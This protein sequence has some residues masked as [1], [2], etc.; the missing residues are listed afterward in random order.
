LRTISLMGARLNLVCSCS[1]RMGSYG[2]AAPET[3]QP[4][5]AL[6]LAVEIQAAELS[7]HQQ[8]QDLAVDPLHSRIQGL[9]ERQHRIFGFGA[10]FKSPA[11]FGASIPSRAITLVARSGP[12]R[13][14]QRIVT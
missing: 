13:R 2:G 9:S 5:H 1:S 6:F 11:S 12:L 8:M 14:G 10:Q 4:Q 3:D 7:T